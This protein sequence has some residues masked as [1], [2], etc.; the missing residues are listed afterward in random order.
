MRN[1]WKKH[2]SFAL[3]PHN[4][5]QDIHRTVLLHANYVVKVHSRCIRAILGVV[6]VVR[7]FNSIFCPHDHIQTRPG[8]RKARQATR[9]A[10]DLLLSSQTHGHMRSIDGANTLQTLAKV[11]TLRT[12]LDRL[13]G[14][15][16]IQLRFQTAK[17]IPQVVSWTLC[18]RQPLHISHDDV[19]GRLSRMSLISSKSQALLVS[20][21]H[22]HGAGCGRA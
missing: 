17:S 14:V 13:D 5:Q 19:V 2:S 1:F 22:T 8:G 21:T 6:Q 16:R 3:F 7:K 10:Q 18:Y 9:S 11:Q 20:S 4:L 12:R 15:W